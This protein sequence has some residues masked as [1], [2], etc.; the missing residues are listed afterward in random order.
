MAINATSQVIR[1]LRINTTNRMVPYMMVLIATFAITGISL[2]NALQLVLQMAYA[3]PETIQL[4]LEVDPKTIKLTDIN[5][6]TRPDPGEMV[7]ILGKL[8]T[9][10]TENEVGIHRGTFMWEAGSNSTEGLTVD[11]G[12]QVFDIKGNGTIVVVGDLPGAGK[13]IVGKPVYGVIAGGTGSYKT[14]TNGEASITHTQH[15]L[16]LVPFDVMLEFERSP[17]I[18]SPT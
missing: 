13:A 9:P 11:I 7:G 8:Y 1:M 5:N 16:P 18:T 3:V 6:N 14:I 12:T 4:K 17:N 15:G 2:T 10:G